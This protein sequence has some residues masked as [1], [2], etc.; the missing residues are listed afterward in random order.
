M[1]QPERPKICKAEGAGVG[2]AGEDNDVR[3][4]AHANGNAPWFRRGLDAEPCMPD[5][6]PHAATTRTHRLLDE[7]ILSIVDAAAAEGITIS[8]KTALRWCIAGKRGV[9]RETLKIGC[10]RM[11]SRAALR[12]FIAATQELDPSPGSDAPD[13]PMLMDREIADRILSRFG[14]GREQELCRGE[15]STRR[16]RRTSAP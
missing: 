11:T 2:V 6:P 14:L 5:I 9:R 4:R 15:R 13:V 10:R 8:S 16:P 7:G 1:L 12:R 3:L